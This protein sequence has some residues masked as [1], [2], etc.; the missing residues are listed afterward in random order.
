[1][2]YIIVMTDIVVV[3]YISLPE[4]REGE[5]SMELEQDHALH[6]LSFLHRDEDMEVALQGDSKMK[7]TKTQW[8]NLVGG[9][10]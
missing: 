5:S 4:P 8:E 6:Q 9:V 2:I 1:M 7:N 3:F 10:L